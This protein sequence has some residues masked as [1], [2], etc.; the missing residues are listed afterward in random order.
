MKICPQNFVCVPDI[1]IINMRL[2]LTAQKTNCTTERPSWQA[3]TTDKLGMERVHFAFALCCHDNA[4]R[5]PIANPPNSAQ[6]VG[7]TYQSPKLH[8]GPCNSVGMRPRTD[9]QTDRHTDAHDHNTFPVV[10]DSC[11]M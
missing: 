1:N 8:P 7:I 2:Q 6:L 9:T 11:E 3:L 5:T 10:Y 4:T